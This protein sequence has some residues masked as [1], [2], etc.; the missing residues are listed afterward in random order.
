[1][2][3]LIMK[4]IQPS[5]FENKVLPLLS[6][7]YTDT[8]YGNQYDFYR[9]KDVLDQFSSGQFICKQWAVDEV[10]QFIE[11]EDTIAVIG[12]WYGLM[13]HMLAE[14]GFTDTIFDYEIDEA[15]INLH[16]H[17]KVHDNVFICHKDGFDTCIM[18]GLKEKIIICT[19]CEHIDEEDLYDYMSMKNPYAK[20]LLQSNN[21]FDIDSHV[22]CHS[23]VDHFIESLPEMDILY[24]GTKQIDN[25]ERYMVIAK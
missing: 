10:Q 20:V 7:L 4:Y 3:H 11:P 13:S 21:M 9:I 14:S 5:F 2:E 18:H 25:Y 12:G 19:A 1:M 23:S 6:F 16:G 24:K 8:M 15:C 22:N 17:L